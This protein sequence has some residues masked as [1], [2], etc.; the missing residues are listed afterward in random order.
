MQAFLV[1]IASIALGE[2]GDK[3]QLLALILATQLRRPLLV[4]LG[5]SWSTLANHLLAAL[6]G[7]WAGALLESADPALDARHLLPGAGGMGADS[8]KGRDRSR[9]HAT[10]TAP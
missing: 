8:G 3:T 10:A 9:G 5:I 6:L 2:L 7:Q 1:S 4:L